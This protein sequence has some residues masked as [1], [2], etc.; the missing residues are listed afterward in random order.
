VLRHDAGHPL[1]AAGA[2]QEWEATG[3]LGLQG[4]IFDLVPLAG[5]G[6]AVLVP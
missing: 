3:R 4:R 2:D 1:L 6:G 5:H